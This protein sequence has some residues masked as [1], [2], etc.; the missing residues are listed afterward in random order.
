MAMVQILSYETFL[1]YY[2]K[3][4]K[5]NTRDFSDREIINMIGWMM[6]NLPINDIV[7]LNCN[8]SNMLISGSHTVELIKYINDNIVTCLQKY[9]KQRLKNIKEYEWK[10]TVQTNFFRLIFLENDNEVF[11]YL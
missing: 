4:K 1:K 6:A 2:Y 5:L 11:Y 10:T 7:V 3:E 8:D 9:N